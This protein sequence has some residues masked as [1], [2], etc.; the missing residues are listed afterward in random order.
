MRT[1]NTKYD[2]DVIETAALDNPQHYDSPWLVQ[3]ADGQL[4]GYAT[5]EAACAFQR[6]WRQ[7]H[8]FDPVTGVKL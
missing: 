6:A 4:D 8:G 3:F 7:E 5:E 2:V 1:D